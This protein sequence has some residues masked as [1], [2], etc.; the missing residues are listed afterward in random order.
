MLSLIH[1]I[2]L[3]FSA[4]NVLEYIDIKWISYLAGPSGNKLDQIKGG[5]WRHTNQ[6]VQHHGSPFADFRPIGHPNYVT[7]AFVEINT[8]NSLENNA[9]D[10]EWERW[11]CRLQ[12]W[13]FMQWLINQGSFYA[14]H[15]SQSCGHPR[16]FSTMFYNCLT[17]SYL[18]Q[19]KIDCG[20][21][22]SKG[23][24]CWSL[25]ASAGTAKFANSEYISMSSLKKQLNK[26]VDSP[27]LCSFPSL[28]RG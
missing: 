9:E 17:C 24:K 26:W 22:I 10:N 1:I 3:V 12:L 25:F 7:L 2:R 21:L 19:K 23:K 28:T 13:H 27:F 4:S 16:N 8:M 15:I 5:A 14:N 11:R 6:N 18:K 20:S